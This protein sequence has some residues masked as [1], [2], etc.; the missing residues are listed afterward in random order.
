MPTPRSVP[1]SARYIS[2]EKISTAAE[3]SASIISSSG[4]CFDAFGGHVGIVRQR[5]VDLTH[6]IEQASRKTQRIDQHDSDK[7]DQRTAERQR[8]QA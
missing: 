6:Q 8:R 5:C 3:R 1:S 2:S 7:N 4:W